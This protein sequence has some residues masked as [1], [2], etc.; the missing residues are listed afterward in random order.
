VAV[1]ENAVSLELRLTGLQGGHSGLD[2]HENRGNAIKLMTR[3]LR[4][5]ETLDITISDFRSGDKI[6]AIPRECSVGITLQPDHLSKAGEM[7]NDLRE[8]FHTEFPHEPR[9]LISYEHVSPPR[10]VV[11][12][13]SVKTML[14]LLMAF[15]HGVVAMSRDIPA[16]VETSNNLSSAHI[17][18]DILKVHNT[19]RSSVAESLQVV[20]DQI[21]AISDLAGAEHKVGLSYPGWQPDPQSKLL[22]LVEETHRELFGELPKR[23]ATHAGLECGVIGEKL[24][25]IDM[26]SIGP[27][28]INCHSPD[29]AVSIASVE[30]LWK[31]MTGVLAK[32]AGG[33]YH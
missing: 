21:L 3:I 26:V 27:D 18:N 4:A 31:L 33:S 14:N 8:L 17:K 2:I 13:E 11:H 20:I 15:P 28:M 6:N 16:L 25:G 7:I 24:G 22:Q 32:V 30:K 1:P 9:L 10:T 19:P 12:A 23:E 29:E 5:L